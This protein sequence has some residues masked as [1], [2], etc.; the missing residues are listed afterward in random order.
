MLALEENTRNT[1]FNI[2]SVEANARL[3]IKEI[4][5][6]YTQEQLDDWQEQD[7]WFSDR[8]FAFD[9]FGS[10]E[11]DEILSQYPIHGKGT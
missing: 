5:D 9:H 3:Y 1:A 8:F 2:M 4:R 11:N 7:H 10:M 6:Q